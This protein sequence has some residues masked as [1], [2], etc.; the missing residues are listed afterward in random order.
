MCFPPKHEKRT[1][2]SLTAIQLWS[3]VPDQYESHIHA[4]DGLRARSHL[5]ESGAKRDLPGHEKYPKS[6][7]KGPRSVDSSV[8]KRPPS[9]LLVFSSFGLDIGA[10]VHTP[11]INIPRK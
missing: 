9:S 4:H 1:P 10:A 3:E 7:D 5:P 2:R 6:S 11:L 8:M